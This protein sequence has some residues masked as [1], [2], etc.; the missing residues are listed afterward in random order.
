MHI[1]RTFGYIG[2]T[3]RQLG[4]ILDMLGLHYGALAYIDMTSPYNVS[5]IEF[6]SN[7]VYIRSTTEYFVSTLAYV[8]STLGYIEITLGHVR[9]VGCTL[10][11]VWT[12]FA[13]I[14]FV[15]TEANIWGMLRVL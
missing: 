14:A 15:S 11:N 12:Y 2:S 9:L 5:N 13:C 4:N 6:M 8:G 1:R 10:G 7:L 3:L